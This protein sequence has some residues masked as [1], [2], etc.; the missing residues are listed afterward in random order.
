MR[1]RGI[2]TMELASRIAEH[3][4]TLRSAGNLVIINVD[5]G[6]VGG[7]VIDRLRAI[8][9]DVN[10]IQFGGKAQDGKKYANRRAEIWGLMRDWLKGGVIPGDEELASDLCSVEYGFNA[11]DQ[12]ILEKKESMKSRGLASPDS[13][14]AL[15]LTFAVPV[16]VIDWMDDYSHRNKSKNNRREFDPYAIINNKYDPYASL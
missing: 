4:N 13:A 9:F 3:A 11:N 14:D 6:G 15:A 1:F 12:I 5:G 7:G 8:G 2:D 16:P 10:E